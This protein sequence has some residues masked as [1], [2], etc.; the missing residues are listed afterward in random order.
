MPEA[1]EPPPRTWLNKFQDAFEGVYL[2]TA[3][4]SSFI[5]HGLAFLVVLLLGVTLQ[6]EAWQWTVVLLVSGLVVSLELVNSAIESLARAVTD[7]YHPCIDQ[8]LKIASA[9]VLIAALVSVF[10]GLIVFVPPL[11]KLVG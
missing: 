2:G 10:V 8:A 9:A 11:W 3:G 5:V 6:I 1:F 7:E 4:Q